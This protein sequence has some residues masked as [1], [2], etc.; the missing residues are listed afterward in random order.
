MPPRPGVAATPAAPHPQRK[1]GPQAAPPGKTMALPHP[2]AGPARTRTRH[3]GIFTS[4]AVLVLM[5]LIVACW[6]LWTKAVDQYASTVGFS[7]RKEEMQ[8][9]IDLFGGITQLSGSASSDTDILYEFILSQEMVALID[10]KLN[11]VARYSR[12]WPEDPVF[13]YPPTGQ[14]EDLVTYWSR[15][16]KVFYDA[17]TGLIEVRALAFTPQDA[18]VIATTVFEESSHM[19]NKL[20]TIARDDATRYAREDLDDAIE[21]LKDARQK[22]TEFRLRTRIVDPKADIQAQMGLLNTLQ[23]Q[24]ASALIDLD[25]LREVTRASDP[26]LSQAE[27][28]IEVIENRIAQEREKFGVGGKGPGG[29]DYATMMA[30]HE[31]LSV[32]LQFAEQAYTGALSAHTAAVAE[33]RRQ[34]RYLAAYIRPTIA[35][36]AQYPRRL[37]LAGLTGLFLLL[38]WAIGVLIYYSVRDRR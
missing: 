9:A 16:V 36:S 28:R 5:P 38:G 2:V 10:R 35:Q 24:L 20:S 11:L 30:E 12:P 3:F 18:Q 21:R 4:F 25:L 19:I 14:I 32:D 13:A 23:T 33:S 27:R 8:S 31:R 22:V 7:V 1:S 26:R 6:Y 34:S 15:M 17:G 37:M 29:E